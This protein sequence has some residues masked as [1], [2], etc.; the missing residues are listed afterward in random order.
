MNEPKGSA[1]LKRKS[2]SGLSRWIVI[3]LDPSS[4]TIPWERSHASFVHLLAPAD[5]RDA[6]KA[7]LLAVAALDRLA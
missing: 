4:A 5:L 6:R 2:G 7:C 3:V 1:S